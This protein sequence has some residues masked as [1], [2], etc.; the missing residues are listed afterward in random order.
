MDPAPLLA[1][2][3]H[4]IPAKIITDVNIKLNPKIDPHQI[5]NITDFFKFQNIKSAKKKNTD[6]TDTTDFNRV[7][8]HGRLTAVRI[9]K[10]S[11]FSWR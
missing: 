7:W 11:L 10:H 1:A 3:S 8:D 4:T 5:T 2:C 6:V 9:P